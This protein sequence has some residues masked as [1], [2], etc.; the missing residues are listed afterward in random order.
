MRCADWLQSTVT[1]VGQRTNTLQPYLSISGELT[2]ENDL[3]MRGSRIVIPS[4]L[5]QDI[6]NKIQAGHQGI[7]K[8]REMA[9]QSVWWPGISKELEELVNRCHLCCKAQS[10]RAEP[11]ITTPLP[12]LPW[13]KVATDKFEWRNQTISSLWTIIQDYRVC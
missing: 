9:C 8:C 1:R 7:T 13:Q 12:N 2:I 5:R 10:Q 6:L 3:L 11:L 4:S